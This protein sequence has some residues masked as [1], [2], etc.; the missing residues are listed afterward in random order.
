M[1]EG[2]FNQ[3]LVAAITEPIPVKDQTRIDV[4]CEHVK[5]VA[6]VPRLALPGA[7]TLSIADR[8]DG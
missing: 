1:K 6:R 7:P 8:R 5:H 2:P 3:S 4:V